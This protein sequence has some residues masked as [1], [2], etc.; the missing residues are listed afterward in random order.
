M[1]PKTTHKSKNAIP[2]RDGVSCMPKVRFV[3]CTLKKGEELL[4]FGMKRALTGVWR[5]IIYGAGAPG[6]MSGDFVEA[7]VDAEMGSVV[8]YQV[9]A[10][11]QFADGKSQGPGDLL[12]DRAGLRHFEYAVPEVMFHQF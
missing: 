6:I 4:F 12:R 9:Q 11:G 7:Y 1:H 10:G 8:F 3:L 2:G 5:K